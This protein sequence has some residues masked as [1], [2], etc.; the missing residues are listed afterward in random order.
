VILASGFLI[1]LYE[2]VSQVG[3]VV[4]H[5][6]KRRD[7]PSSGLC[8]AT[9]DALRWELCNGDDSAGG[10]GGGDRVMLEQI[11]HPNPPEDPFHR[12][13]SHMEGASSILMGIAANKSIA[14][15]QAVEVDE[16]LKL[17]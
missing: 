4:N 1:L 8:L 11:F 2:T 7:W 5:S 10:H 13:A 6:Y 14:A 12:A 15:G 17:P 16:L 9:E 3:T